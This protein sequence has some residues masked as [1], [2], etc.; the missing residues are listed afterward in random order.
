MR[1]FARLRLIDADEENP[2]R[3]AHLAFF[4]DLCQRAEFDSGQPDDES[5]LE[6]LNA[7]DVEADN[8]RAALQYCLADPD[9]ADVG[10]AMA[11]GLGRYWWSRALSE[12]VHW[13]EALLERRGR[14]DATRARALFVRSYLAV[15]QGDQAAGLEAAAEA[16]AIARRLKANELLVRILAIQAALQVM[17]GDVSAGRASSAEAK[18]LAEVLGED[19][20]FIAAAQSEAFIAFV[21]GDFVRMRDIGFAAA[22]R[23]RKI[24]E[25]YMLSTHLTSAGMGSLMLGEHTPAE[26]ALI[27]ALRASLAI[28]DRPGLAL[29]L[30]ALAYS[31]AMAGQM[32]RSAR[33]LGASEMLRLETGALMSP[34]MSL[35]VE[36]AG[37]LARAELGDERF[38]T[39]FD[40]GVRLDREAAIALALGTKGAQDAGRATDMA[41]DPLGKREREIA[42]LIAEGLSNKE[43]ANRL[44]LSER[45]V[46]THVYNILNK[47]GFN[48][49]VKIAAWVSA[50]E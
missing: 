14:D 20:P 46:E 35:L 24:H 34:L 28:D 42:E 21:D 47:L 41:P 27:E 23:C 29:R 7:L 39:A 13:I 15:T 37:K 50:K 16:G 40:Y 25:L 26:S 6:A 32:Q 48:S 22:A 1:E 17:A 3:Q 4:A 36:P 19:V 8:V 49:R 43:I 11:A 12:G 5:K 2:A 33:L 18:A 45:T 9:G 44:F 31:A 10:L 30:Q 38:K